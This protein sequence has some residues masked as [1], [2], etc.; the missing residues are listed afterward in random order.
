MT[1]GSIIGIP[2]T[3]GNRISVLDSYGNYNFPTA[4]VSFSHSVSSVL[5][6]IDDLSISGSLDN[7]TTIGIIPVD[8][9]PG[10]II[11]YR[12]YNGLKLPVATQSVSEFTVR[13]TDQ[14]GVPLNFRYL[15]SWSLTLV[16]EIDLFKIPPSRLMTLGE[17]GN[18]SQEKFLENLLMEEE[19]S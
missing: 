6:K 2:F 4:P 16:V 13:L 19:Y 12:N 7:S 15:K 5:V 3:S 1:C 10:Q 14:N 8:R 17:I 11:H 9:E 18:F